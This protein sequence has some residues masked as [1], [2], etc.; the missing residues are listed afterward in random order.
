MV[1][2]RPLCLRTRAQPLDK[3]ERSE[4]IKQAS[5]FV[6]PGFKLVAK[7]K[8]S[9][10]SGR[11]RTQLAPRSQLGPWGLQH[12]WPRTRL[13]VPCAPG[14]RSAAGTSAGFALLAATGCW[15]CLFT[16]GHCGALLGWPQVD[17]K[18]IGGFVLEFED[19]LV[20][21]STSKKVR[22]GGGGAAVLV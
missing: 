21:L 20:D 10:L 3:L 14:G 8:V 1:T 6:E 19:R 5:K 15:P 11:G 22:A 18:L 7:E 17:K 16:L 4:V 12:R 9:G 13:C 2:L